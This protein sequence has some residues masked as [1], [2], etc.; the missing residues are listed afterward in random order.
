MESYHEARLIMTKQIHTA[1]VFDLLSHQA[2]FDEQ[3]LRKYSDTY[4]PT[5]RELYGGRYVDVRTRERICLN[6]QNVPTERSTQIVFTKPKKEVTKEL[7][8]Y[9]YFTIKKDK[10]YRKDHD[11]H[12]LEEYVQPAGELRYV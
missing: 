9:N 6:Q 7:D 10:R 4:Y 8:Q 1:D 3:T 11:I 12:G 5:K 2:M